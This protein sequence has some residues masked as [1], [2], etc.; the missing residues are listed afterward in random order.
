MKAVI[1]K[2]FARIHIANLINFG[3]IPMTL[4]DESDYDKIN[5]GDD[6]VI[7]GFSDAVAGSDF[8]YVCVNGKEKIKLNLNFSERQREILLAGGM[9]NYTKNK[10]LM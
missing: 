6:L 9:L 2:S 8:A 1:A 4:A 10:G 3:I 7:E 5:E